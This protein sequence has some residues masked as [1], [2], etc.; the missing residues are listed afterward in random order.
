MEPMGHDD[1]VLPPRLPRLP[2]AEPR[3]LPLLLSVGDVVRL[4]SIS[5]ATF[6]AS[7]PAGGFGP[8]TRDA[9]RT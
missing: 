4:L 3:S 9:A 5:R 1:A 6:Y 8:S 2:G 7:S